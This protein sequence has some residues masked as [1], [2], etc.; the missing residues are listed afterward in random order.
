[1]TDLEYRIAIENV[2]YL[3]SCAVNGTTPEKERVDSLDLDNL[4]KS[5]QKHMLAAMV[6]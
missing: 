3:C 6:G 2:I 4:Y 1:M 5:A